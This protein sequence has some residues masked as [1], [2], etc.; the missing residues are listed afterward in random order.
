MWTFNLRHMDVQPSPYQR[1][2]FAMWTVNHA[3]YRDV[4]VRPWQSERCILAKW[5]FNHG[6]INHGRCLISMLHSQS[7][8]CETCIFAIS[9]VHL[10]PSC[11][12]RWTM[13]LGEIKHG[14]W[15]LK[16]YYG[17]LARAYSTGVYRNSWDDCFMSPVNY[18]WCFHS[19]FLSVPDLTNVFK[20]W[21]QLNYLFRFGI[22]ISTSYKFKFPRRWN[23]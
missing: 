4:K 22:W 17:V 15:I 16:I 9:I 3:W 7:S 11:Y 1:S 8:R 10:A 23:K 6:H 14:P 21:C 20:E 12:E 2:T 18:A 19:F 13:L 5:T